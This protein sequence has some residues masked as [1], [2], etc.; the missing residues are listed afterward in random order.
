MGFVSAYILYRDGEAAVIDTGLANSEQAVADALAAIGLGWDS[1]GHVV[2]THK[3]DDHMLGLPAVLDRAP[4]AAWYAGEEDMQFIVAPRQGTV[5]A[6]ADNVFDL[7]IIKTPGHTL[8]HISVLDELSGI[9]VAGDALRV[10]EGVLRPSNPQ[11][12][13]VQEMAEESIAKLATF[14]YEI[15]LFG[16]G[17]PIVTGASAKV[18]ALAAT[19]G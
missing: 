4:E 7:T 16:H 8:G 2:I 19:L 9:L 18:A 5:V 10:S 1:V 11:F 12:T 3:H 6:D 14:E 17:E 13:M 15:A